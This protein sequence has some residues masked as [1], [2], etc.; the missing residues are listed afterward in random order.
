MARSNNHN[1]YVLCSDIGGSGTKTMLYD[2]S[3]KIVSTA[4]KSSKLYHPETGATIQRVEEVMSSV[5]LTIREC[6]E[7][8][9]VDTKNIAG[10]IFD[11]QQ[12]GLMWIDRDYNAV[13]DYD[14]WMDTRY[15][16]Y[17][18]RIIEE[19][20]EAILQKTGT[21]YGIVHAPKMVWWKNDH[22]SIYKKAYKMLLVASYVGGKFCGLKG[23]DAY[24]E[25]TTLGFSG[26]ADINTGEWD[27]DICKSCGIDPDKLPIITSPEKIVGKLCSEYARVLNLPEGIPIISGAGDFPAAGIGA[28]ILKNNQLGDI[29]GTASLVFVANDKWKPDPT[30]TLRVCKS[31]MK[32]MWFT[33]GFTTGGG[34][35]RWF[36]DS[37]FEHDNGHNIFA[38]LNEAA[39]DL[40]S[41]CNG[42]GFYPYIGG[43]HMNPTYR[44]AWIGLDF[45]HNKNFL[46][47][48]IL[49]GVAYE[50]RTY[51]DEMKKIL[52]VNPPEMRI[53]GGGSASIVWNQIKANVLGVTCSLLHQQEC[54]LLGSAI[55]AG[56]ALGYYESIE[57]GA[58]NVNKV[59]NTFE[60]EHNEMELYDQ[61]YFSWK[62]NLVQNDFL[63]GLKI[64]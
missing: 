33:F 28:G 26:L 20:G 62:K 40:P 29:A 44:G 17:L 61:F 63:Y 36:K 27:Y 2:L 34:G 6:L 48:S 8:A 45:T 4:F 64:L 39:A 37:F 24:Y 1:V 43:T 60:P 15:N 23:D 3:G 35:L 7:K 46:Y 18:Q 56:S 49:E 52:G 11:G 47:K 5:V 21:S 50:Y 19:C 58:I 42:L 54:S 22:P 41:G 32:G 59:K 51:L 14:S 16:K 31:P 30:G 55:I 38:E 9:R 25:E 53:I 13:S 10:I 12:S 57:D